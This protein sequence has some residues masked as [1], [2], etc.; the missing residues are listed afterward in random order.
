M[1]RKHP[2]TKEFEERQREGMPELRK[3]LVGKKIY[4]WHKKKG[5]RYMGEV[6]HV[7]SKSVLSVEDAVGRRQRVPV[8]NIHRVY[9]FKNEVPLDEWLEKH[10]ED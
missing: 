9:W 5:G 10:C 8:W 6:K 7:E 3:C 1:A 4:F 2:I